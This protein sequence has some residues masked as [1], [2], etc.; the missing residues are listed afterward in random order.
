M[1]DIIDYGPLQPLIG[2]WEGNKGLDIAPESDG[3]TEV[4]PYSER[5]VFE[6]AGCL[7]NAE[8]QN[9]SMLRYHQVVKRKSDDGIFRIAFTGSAESG[10]LKGLRIIAQSIARISKNSQLNIKLILYL[11][12]SYASRVKPHMADFSFV[13]FRPHPNFSNLRAELASVDALL[14]AYGTD[15]KTINYYRYSFA[16]KIVP[17]MMSGRAIFVYGP[18]EIEPVAYAKRD[19]WAKVCTSELPN[20]LNLY[21]ESYVFYYLHVVFSHDGIYFPCSNTQT[22]KVQKQVCLRT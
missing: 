7:S 19:S 11:T 10:Q 8:K 12:E 18:V 22:K 17:Y 4:D 16:T 14:L 1:E 9:L 20:D 13:E 2:V 15:A 21:Q 3:T 6:E 5:I